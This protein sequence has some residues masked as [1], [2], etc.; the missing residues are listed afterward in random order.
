MPSTAPWHSSLRCTSPPAGLV[1]ASRWDQKELSAGPPELHIAEKF[2][3]A[4][5]EQAA[6]MRERAERA[7]RR[8]RQRQRAEIRRSPAEM[9]I[10]Q[11]LW[12]M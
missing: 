8:Q 3:L 9:A 10:R 5:L 6:R 12:E 7:E 4:Y 11:W 1:D 2:R